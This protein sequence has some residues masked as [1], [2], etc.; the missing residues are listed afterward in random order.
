M[1]KNRFLMLL[2]LLGLLLVLVACKGSGGCGCNE[3]QEENNATVPSDVAKSDLDRDLA[4]DVDEADITALVAGNSEFAMDMFQYL[5]DTDSNVFFSPYSMSLGFAMVYGGARTTTELQMKDVFHFNLD[6][7]ALHKT[8][9][10]LDLRL[11]PVENPTREGEEPGFQL[12]IANSFWAEQSYTFLDSYLDLLGVNYGAEIQLVDFVQAYEQA[13][14]EIN[15][16][17]SVETEDLIPELFPVG[18]FNDLTRFACVNTIYFKA[19]WEEQFA[20]IDTFNAP[21]HTPEGD[22]D[23][24]MMQLMTS[25]SYLEGDDF[26]AVELPYKGNTTSMVLLLPAEGCYDLFEQSLDLDIY[27]SII[28]QMESTD[29]HLYMPKFKSSPE[30]LDLKDILSYLGMPV[31][32]AWPGADFSA[33]AGDLMLYLDKAF[34][35]AVIEVNERYTEAA[36]ATGSSGGYGGGPVPT[37]R[38]DRPFIYLIRDLDT[39]SI[40]FMG[41]MYDPT[42]TPM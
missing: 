9:N 18:S 14:K 8:F 32:F 5:A 20:E 1:A 35:Q 33:M 26:Q 29:V 27:N 39:G 6:Q 15:A 38:A 30:A 23:V 40:L 10:S 25:L 31:A 16:W 13:R 41:R 3:D 11:R 28:E 17:T 19:A 34:H 2:A 12:Q 22:V 4:P 21:F 36:A 42:E 37:F 24:P 7:D